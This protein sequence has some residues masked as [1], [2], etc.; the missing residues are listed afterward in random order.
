MQSDGNLAA[1]IRVPSLQDAQYAISQLH[2][3]KIG[4]KRM[5]IS[6]PNHN[7]QSPELKRYLKIL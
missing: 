3:K 2:R 6:Y 5:I 1:T 4:S 7:Q